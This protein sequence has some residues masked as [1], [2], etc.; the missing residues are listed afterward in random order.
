MAWTNSKIFMAFVEDALENTAALA[1]DTDIPKVAL[2]DND[3]TPD[4]TVATANSI[5]NAG[6]WASAGNEVFDEELDA[7]ERIY[8]KVA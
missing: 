6:V 7:S 8:R 2:Y 1:L 3:I 4:Q 5:F